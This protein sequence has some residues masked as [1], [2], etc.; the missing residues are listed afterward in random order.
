MA[1][2]GDLINTDGLKVSELSSDILDFVYQKNCILLN[3]VGLIFGIE[4]GIPCPILGFEYEVPESIELLKFSYSE[5]PF[6]DRTSL[7]NAYFKEN[8]RFALKAHRPITAKNPFAVN[9]ALNEAIYTALE[10]YSLNGGTY[11]ILTG[12]K[13]ITYAVLEKLTGIKNSDN[14]IGGQGF[15]FEFLK[16]NIQTNEIQNIQNDFLSAVTSGKAI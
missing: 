8:T 7:I 16:L 4:T 6:L 1:V 3:D 5:Y 15:V 13:T 11:T 12:H 2:I 14:D 10:K 9:Y